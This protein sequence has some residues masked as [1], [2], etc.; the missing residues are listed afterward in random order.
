MTYEQIRY[1][2]QDDLA[3]VTLDRPERLNAWTGRMGKELSDAF[4]RANAERA[5]GAIVVTGEGRGFCAGADIQDSFKRDLDRHDAAAESPADEPARERELPDWVQLCRASKPLV[6]AVNGPAIGVGLTMILPFDQIIASDRARLSC[7]FVKMGITPELA[8]SHFLVSRMGWGGAS[9]LAL[10]GR[11]VDAAEAHALRLVD[12][13][14]PH[15][16]LLDAATVK[17]RQ[18]SA[19]PDPQLRMI[20]ELLTENAVETDLD[21][22]QRREI[23]ALDAALRTPEHR[24]AVDAFLAKREPRFR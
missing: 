5:I 15:D 3:V 8:S 1:E 11:I 6:A 17:A 12:A 18:F 9:D 19:N 16:E 22:V 10:T 14:V 21:G 20:K 2:Q 7:R 13:V 24:E 23:A 4:G